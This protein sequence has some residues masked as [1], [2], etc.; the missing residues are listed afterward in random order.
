MTLSADGTAPDRPTPCVRDILNKVSETAFGRPLVTNVLRGLVVEAIVAAALEPQW[1]WCAEDYSSWDFQR[2]DGLRLEVKQSAARQSWA[3]S[4]KP[5]QCSFDIAQRKGRWEGP[6][7]IDA[8]GRAAQLYVFAHHPVADSSA[9]HRD[10]SQW[11]FYVVPTHDLPA[12]RRL[13][14]GAASRLTEPVG[15]GELATKVQTIAAQITRVVSGE[16]TLPRPEATP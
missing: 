11:H 8:P 5:S 6:I 16:T 13:S 3:V 9:D 12:T 14:L 7:W 2:A 10:P 4:D 15:F 1:Q